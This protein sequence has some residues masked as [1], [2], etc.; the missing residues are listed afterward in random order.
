[1]ILIDTGPIVALFDKNDNYHDKCLSLLKTIKEPLITTMPVL[2]EAFYL[3]GFSWQVQ[4]ALWEFVNQGGIQIYDLKGEQF[5]RCR[6]LM[7]KYKDLP[8]DLAD[9]TIV[10]AAETVNISTIFTIDKDFRIYRTK[11]GKNFRL[12]PGQ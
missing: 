4:D 3:L 12:I 1:M 5:K 2:T 9:A 7:K 6:E 8:M 10:S 11:Q